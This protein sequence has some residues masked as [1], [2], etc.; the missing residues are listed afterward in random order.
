MSSII[1]QIFT[2]DSVSNERVSLE[3]DLHL[4][5]ELGGLGSW[6]PYLGIGMQVETL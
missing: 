3:Y 4:K 6:L 1:A 2:F 5:Y